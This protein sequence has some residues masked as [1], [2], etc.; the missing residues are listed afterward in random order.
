MSYFFR[1]ETGM[2]RSLALKHQ[3]VK[4]LDDWQSDLHAALALAPDHLSAYALSYEAGT[5]FHAWRQ[6]GRLRPVPEDDE[7]AMLD[8]L[9]TSTAAEG[10]ER[11]EVSSWARPGRS[12]RH[13][14]SYWDGSDYLGIG[15]GAHS[16]CTQPAPG[17]RF[18]NERLPDAYRAAVERDGRAVASAETLTRT[19]AS[20]DFVITGLR[21]VVGVDATVF[22]L[23]FGEPIETVFPKI[24]DLVRD[25]LLVQTD[26]HV[27]L[28]ARG[29]LFAD[30]VAGTFV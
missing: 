13:N 12:S 4:A 22:A 15:P 9:T 19:Q 11:Y 21:R 29:L 24:A 17:I 28:S 20:A 23:R 27:R 5:P 2:E 10:F 25:G 14:Q 18:V 8:Y 6:S 1:F 26:T 16:F 30:S 7:V 3:L